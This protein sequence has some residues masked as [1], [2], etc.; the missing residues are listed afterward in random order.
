M[1]QKHYKIW[2]VKLLWR[3]EKKRLENRFWKIEFFAI[4]SKIDP[5]LII[6]GLFGHFLPFWSFLVI[7]LKLNHDPFFNFKIRNSRSSWSLRIIFFF[8]FISLSN[9]TVVR[10]KKYI[11]VVCIHWIRTYIPWSLREIRFTRTLS[12]YNFESRESPWTAFAS[13]PKKPFNQT[14]SSS[15]RL[16]Q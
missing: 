14:T 4:W 15:Q 11:C 7:F 6:F 3:F 13:C 9:P 5:F 2:Y 1:V 10:K 12:T 16:E 8:F